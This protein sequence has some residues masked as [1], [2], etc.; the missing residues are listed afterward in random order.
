VTTYDL[1]EDRETI[2]LVQQA[3]LTTKDFGLVPCWRTFGR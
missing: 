3:T 2:E 1:A